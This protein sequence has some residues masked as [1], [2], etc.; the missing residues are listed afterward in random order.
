MNFVMTPEEA[1]TNEAYCRA[2][3]ELLY[4]LADDDYIVAYRGSEWLGLAPHIEEDVAFSSITQNTMGHAVMFYELLEQLGEGDADTLAHERD[5]ALRKNAVYLEKKNGAGTYLEEPHYDWALTV[6][7]HFFY[8]TF[9]KIRLEALTQSSYVPLAR[10][11]EKVLMEQPYHLAHWKTWLCQ[12]QQS[13]EEAKNRLMERIDEAWLEILDMLELGLKGGE[14]VEY[15]LIT[16]EAT[17]QQQWVKEMNKSLFYVPSQPLQKQKGNGRDGEH[18]DDLQQA[19]STCS[20]VYNSDR[21]A[22]W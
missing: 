10:A 12:L 20:E 3:I 21:H 19:L 16:D 11:A 15:Q 7:R 6:I 4:Q 13:T 17:I 14:M 18:T 9:K 22:V 2:L 8:E 5:P 1:K